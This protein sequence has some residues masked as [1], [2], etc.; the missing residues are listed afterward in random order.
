M[1]ALFYYN[2]FSKISKRFQ[3]L[4]SQRHLTFDFD[5]LKLRDL[6]KLCFLN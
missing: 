6:A 4:H 1:S 5:D 2:K 3:V